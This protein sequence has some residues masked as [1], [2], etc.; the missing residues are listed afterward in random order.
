MIEH[1]FRSGPKADPRSTYHVYV[2]LVLKKTFIP[3]L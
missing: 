2:T 1:E 3:K